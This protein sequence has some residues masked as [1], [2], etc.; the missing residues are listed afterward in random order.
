MYVS[1]TDRASRLHQLEVN[2]I[3]FIETTHS[4]NIVHDKFIG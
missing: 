4:G 3:A 2:G 1:G